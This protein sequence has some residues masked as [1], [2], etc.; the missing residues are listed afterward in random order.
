MSI[1]STSVA[2]FFRGLRQSYR[3]KILWDYIISSQNKILG[4]GRKSH[5]TY[6][7]PLVT[8]GSLKFRAFFLLFSLWRP[9][10]S[11]KNEWLCLRCLNRFFV[12]ISSIDWY[13][14][15]P[16]LTFVDMV[17]P[18]TGTRWCSDG[19]FNRKFFLKLFLTFW[20]NRPCGKR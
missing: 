9:V 11:V 17:G 10:T 6:L 13:P 19:R 2:V 18:L 3:I 7:D 8:K 15:W 14:N 5:P 1:N 16:C 20:V 4:S 12:W